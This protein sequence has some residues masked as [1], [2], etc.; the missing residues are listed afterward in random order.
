MNDRSAMPLEQRRIV[1]KSCPW[2]RFA[3]SSGALF[4]SV[5]C[6]GKHRNVDFPLMCHFVHWIYC[7]SKSEFRS[8][9]HLQRMPASANGV[10]WLS[11]TRIS[12][13]HDLE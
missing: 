11:V 12:L 7:V 5:D 8:V 9:D 3:I 1:N 4:S 6:A 10:G 2:H 13:F